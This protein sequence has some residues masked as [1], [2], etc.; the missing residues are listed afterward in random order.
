MRLSSL[1]EPQS[2]SLSSGSFGSE[3]PGKR[4]KAE[5]ATVKNVVRTMTE[6][7]QFQ[8]IRGRAAGLAD[9]DLIDLSS[10]STEGTSRRAPGCQA[11]AA[12][13]FMATEIFQAHSLG[14]W[15]VTFGCI[16]MR[17]WTF[18]TVRYMTESTV[19]C[20]CAKANKRLRGLGSTGQF[21]LN[22]LAGGPGQRHGE[23][24]D[25]Q[26]RPDTSHNYAASKYTLFSGQRTVLSCAC[27]L[28]HYKSWEEI[29]PEVLRDIAD[30]AGPR[31]RGAPAGLYSGL[32]RSDCSARS[33]RRSVLKGPSE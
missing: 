18:S 21:P 2:S 17:T 33:R 10:F 31:C 3:K 4:K 5:P 1:R 16:V 23:Q 6:L 20:R 11:V 15:L 19:H 28:E 13:P 30:V 12:L 24:L 9:V 22:S 7:Y 29:P 27:R 26:G 14:A 8:R 32:G 25:R